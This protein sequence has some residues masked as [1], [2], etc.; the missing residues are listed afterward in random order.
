MARQPLAIKLGGSGARKQAK[1]RQLADELY[2]SETAHE[3]LLKHIE[4][5][6]QFGKPVRDALADRF[7]TIDRAVMGYLK[8]DPDDRKRQRDNDRGKGPKATD[9]ILPL[10]LTQLDEAM[11]YL[12]TVIAPDDGMYS[13]ISTKEK[14]AQAKGFASL[15][16]KNDKTFKHYENYARALFDMLKY[17]I[18]GLT[19]VWDR[20]IGNKI[21][22]DATGSPKIEKSVVFEGNKVE[23][24]DMYNCIFDPSVRLTQ[25]N[26]LG[27]FFALISPETPFRLRRMKENREIFFDDK[28]VLEASSA[29][30]AVYYRTRPT[31]RASDP[32]ESQGTDWVEILTAG[33]SKDVNMDYERIEYYGWIIPADFELSDVEEYQIWRFTILNSKYIVAAEWL[34]NA[35]GMLPCAFGRP[36]NDGFENQTKSFAEHLM[37]Y[38]NFASFQMNVHQR[39]S[40]KA[41]YG[42]TFYNRRMFPD[43]EN[44]DL[45]SAKVPFNPPGYDNSFDIRKHVFNMHDAPETKN[46]L[47]DITAVDDLMQ[48][49]LPT[50]MLRQVASLERAT[51]YQAAATVQGANRRNHKIAKVINSQCLVDIREMQMYNIYQFQKQLTILD[52]QGNETQI[53]P[54]E[55]RESNIEYDISDGLKGIDKLSIFEGI[56]DVINML[57]QSPRAGEVDML[58]L[59]DWWTSLIGEKTDFRQFKFETQFDAL[60]P[61]QKQMAFQLLQQAMEQQAATQPGGTNGAGGAIQPVIPQMPGAA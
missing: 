32:V 31:I 19:C 10:V 37:P 28:Y 34:N 26:Q 2:I 58:A 27:E 40:R 53:N 20:I 51:Q 54:A 48:R 44:E 59:I 38:Q 17:N 33:V 30:E 42:T 43:L 1:R 12:M 49:I 61:E 56:K 21:G 3:K 35:H 55:F 11:T 9:Q 45:T 23:S 7:E 39:S 41:L 57:L 50:D 6:L 25:L 29:R 4:E 60:L 36:W 18:G 14:Q 8:L 13:A 15:M 16:N 24:I 22:N 46:T 5:R 52:D 47:Q